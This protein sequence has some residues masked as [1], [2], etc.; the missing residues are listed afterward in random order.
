M[1]RGEIFT[2]PETAKFMVDK[3]GNL[4]GKCILEPGAGEGVFVRELLRRK[5]NPQQVTAIEINPAFEKIYQSLGINYKITDFLL[6]EDPVF[7][8]KFFDCVIGNPP[9][10][11]RHSTYL[12]TNKKGLLRRFKEIGVYDTYSLFIYRSLLSLKEGGIL[13]FIVSDTFLTI[14]YHQKLR[15][16]LL[17]NFKVSEVILA[18]KNLFS[19]QGVNNNPCIVVIEKKPWNDSHEAVF[20]DRVKTEREYYTPSR[21]KRIPQQFFL[22]IRGYPISVNVDKV[23]VRL[24]SSLPS[25]NEVIK[26]QIGLHTHDNERF[27]AA[28][29]GTAL[30][31]KFKKEGRKVI[32]REVLLDDNRWRPYLKK[33]GNEQYYREIEEAIDWSNDAVRYYDVPKKNNLFFNEGI[34]IS[35][36]S[37][38]LAARYMPPGCLWDTNKAMGFV[39]KDGKISIWYVLGLLNSKLYNFLAKGILN[40]TNC[41]QIDDIRALPFKH[42]PMEVLSLIGNLVKHIVDNLKINSCYDYSGEQQEIDEL[43]FELY[44][45]PKGLRDFI[46]VNY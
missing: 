6:D 12:R 40:S 28:I 32:T 10:L 31:R 30:S 14:G 46:K 19:K 44:E 37:S 38:K 42:P 45:I 21:V 4:T 9:Y 18:P 22:K 26:G 36:V 2:P 23:V 5:V 16:C 35:G 33:G 17:K 39:V 25:I 11:S 13:C 8:Q 29:E 41:L 27:I 1:N 43:V 7:T 24:F 20:V 15:E 34:V 3:L